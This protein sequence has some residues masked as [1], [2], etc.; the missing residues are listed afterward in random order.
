MREE[1]RRELEGLQ[2][3]GERRVEEG[4]RQGDRVG[5]R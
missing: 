5:G 3:R 2:E 4:A 1:E